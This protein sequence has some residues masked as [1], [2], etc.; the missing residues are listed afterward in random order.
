MVQ[1]LEPF[2]LNFPFPMKLLLLLPFSVVLSCSPQITRDDAKQKQHTLSRRIGGP[3]ECCEGMYENM[4]DYLTWET[5][6]ADEAEPG[7]R[8]RLSGRILDP[9]GQPAPGVILYVYHTNSEGIYAPAEGQTGCA[10]RHGKLRGWMRTNE[11]GEYAFSTI[12][13]GSYPNTSQP[14]HIHAF[15]KEPDKNE[16]WIDS[17]LFDDDPFL[18][19]GQRQ[20]LDDVGGSGIVRLQQDRYGTGHG[21][22]DIRLGRNVKGY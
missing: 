6:V 12:L 7:Q 3:C 21:V 15:V 13:P 2:F 10:R 19:E 5:A 4:P 8:I 17:F 1:N 22:R 16:Y 20:E 9:D 18:T 14:K 11:K